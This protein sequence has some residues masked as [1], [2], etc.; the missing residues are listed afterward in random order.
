MHAILIQS[1]FW[2]PCRAPTGGGAQR[3]K[4]IPGLT[5][6]AAGRA[7]R[8]V[9]LPHAVSWLQT[10]AEPKNPALRPVSPDSYH[11]LLV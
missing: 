1:H 2:Q 3:L 6:R 10:F 4:S 7:E 5:T 8:V 9:L 11:R